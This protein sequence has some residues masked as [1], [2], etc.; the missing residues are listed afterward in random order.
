MNRRRQYIEVQP[1]CVEL[2]QDV[3][4]QPGTP[5]PELVRNVTDRR[6]VARFS[7]KRLHKFQHFALEMRGTLNLCMTELTWRRSH[8]PDIVTEV[9]TDGR[10]YWLASTWLIA[11]PTVRITVRQATVARTSACAKADALARKTFDHVCDLS[12]C[13]DWLPFVSHVERT[14][15]DG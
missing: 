12:R 15:E 14:H 1:C 6:A 4:S 3:L 5:E 8:G 2:C 7:I 11:N 13:G 10:G 9:A